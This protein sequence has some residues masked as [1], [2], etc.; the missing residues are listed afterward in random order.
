M[1]FDPS[2]WMLITIKS[3]DRWKYEP[4]LATTN[5]RVDTVAVIMMR[6]SL[7][8]SRDTHTNVEKYSLSFSS[9]WLM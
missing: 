3:V 2:Y 6:S 8:H 9:S 5:Q 7:T 1:F 4:A